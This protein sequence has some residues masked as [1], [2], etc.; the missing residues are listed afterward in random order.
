MEIIILCLLIALFAEVFY[1]YIYP[2]IRIRKC[3]VGDIYYK[4]CKSNNPFEIKRMVRKEYTILDIKG[5][6]VQYEEI[7]TY[8]ADDIGEETKKTYLFNNTLYKFF[9]FTVQGSKKKNQI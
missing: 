2:L 8:I 7:E 4:T 1:F 6:Y 9:C 5:K 3:K